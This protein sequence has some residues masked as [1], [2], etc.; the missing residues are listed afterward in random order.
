MEL[1]PGK[2]ESARMD[3]NYKAT[4]LIAHGDPGALDLLKEALQARYHVKLA[5]SGADAVHLAALPPR[6]DLILLDAALP[7]DGGDGGGLAAP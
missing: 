2:F 1:N 3:I 4:I 6:P 7:D 5:A